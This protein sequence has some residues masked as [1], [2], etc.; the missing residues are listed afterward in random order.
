MYKKRAYYVHF[1]C[2]LDS[3][4]QFKPGPCL[5]F[6]S[7]NALHYTLCFTIFLI[8]IKHEPLLGGG[9]R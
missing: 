3:S 7:L 4:L 9:L 1:F 8:Y 2:S 6:I 5:T